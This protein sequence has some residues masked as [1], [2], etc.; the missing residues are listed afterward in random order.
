VSI[1]ILADDEG[2]AGSTRPVFE[3]NGAAILGAAWE[4][5][6]LRASPPEEWAAG[7]DRL[8][9][10]TGTLGEAL[11]DAHPAT[12]LRPGHEA[13]AEACSRL[14]TDLR[15]TGRRIC[16]RPHARHVLSDPASSGAFAR[17]HA[18]RPFEIALDPAAMLESSMLGDVEDHLRRAFA[19][20]GGVA[21]VVM[22]SDVVRG[23]VDDAPL[24]RVPLGRGEL[25][26]GLL[27]S[28]LGDCVPEG[29]PLVIGADDVEG[30]VA[31]L[32]GAGEA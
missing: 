30:Q 7:A 17:E 15:A 19:A 11:F 32:D 3:R 10:W 27:R 1:F 16:F 2:A 14:E 22:L 23:A 20:L 13:L 6:P 28:L 24:R 8:L 4:G 26:G 31:W 9:A 18:D 21:T 5:N 29:T 12:W 25:P